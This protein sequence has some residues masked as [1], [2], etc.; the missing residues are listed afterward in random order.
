MEHWDEL[1]PGGFRF[2][3]DDNVFKPSTDTFLLGDFTEVRRGE[4]VC[5]L[6][7]GIGLLGLLLLA[8]QQEL[9]I[10]NI[11]IDS[12]AC[13]LAEENA[14]VNGL[15]DRVAVLRADLRDR[16]ALPKAGSFD[17]C[18]ANPPYFPPHTGRV[19]EGSRG[20]ARSETACAFDQLCAAAA[21][22]LRSGG[23]FC[24]VHRAER[25]A[26][27]MDV[28]RRH[29]LELITGDAGENVFGEGLNAALSEIERLEQSYLELFLGKQT[30]LVETHRYLVYPEAG[31]NQYVF[32]RFSPAAGLLPDSDL[33]GDMVLLQI[34]PAGEASCSIE[35]GPKE[36][37]VVK[38]RVAA[39]AVCTVIA[40]GREY[41]RAVLPVFE[42]G[43][44]VQVALPRRK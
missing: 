26:E 41:A 21:Y 19:A 27:L 22:L 29:R 6:G 10:T 25:T 9:H 34:E 30:V 44:T 12:A 15:E 39:P 7:A 42:F 11:D 13:A 43:R 3:F 14:A 24:L 1:W 16:T 40:A 8:R 32:C 23:R 35:A 20:T 2:R 37:S 36:S 31:K 4:R 38:C 28:L 33:S 18:V 5:D 17:L